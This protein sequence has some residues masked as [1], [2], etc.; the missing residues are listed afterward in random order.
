[1]LIPDQ[2]V[3]TTRIK[4]VAIRPRQA[5][6]KPAQLL[7]VGDLGIILGKPRMIAAFGKVNHHGPLFVLGPSK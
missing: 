6:T 7:R 1:V 4:L 2:D 3:V 5:E